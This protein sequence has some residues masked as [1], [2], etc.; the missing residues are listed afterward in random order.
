[1]T[2]PLS[3]RRAEYVR[4]GPSTTGCV[5]IA[6][7]AVLLG[8]TLD[9]ADRPELAVVTGGLALSAYA[10]GLMW[11]VGRSQFGDLGLVRWK[12][13]PWTLLWYSLVFGIA[14]VTWSQPQTGIA[15]QIA[16]SSVLRSLWLVTVG[17]TC[18]TIGYCADPGTSIRGSVQRGVD[19]L[20]SRF[21]DEIRS[22]AAPWLLYAIGLAARLATVATTGRL[23]YVG[24]VSSA[25]SS[26]SGLAGLLGALSLCAPLA[27]SAAAL[28]VFR[29]RL[30]HARATLLVLFAVELAFGA[31]AGGKQNF[32]I[33][34]LAV[35]IPFCAARR[36]LPK[37]SLVAIVLIFL[38]IVMPF[39]QAYRA[40]ARQGSVTL[41]PGQALAAAPQILRQTV[42]EQNPLAVVPQSIDE[43]I[44]RIRDIDSPAFYRYGGW[45]PVVLGMFLIGSGVRLLDNIVD[46]RAN[47]Q[48][49]FLV[50]LLFPS[51][52]RGEYDW[53]AIVSSLPS[54]AVVWLLSVALVFRP[55]RSG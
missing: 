39:N 16:V 17:L 55:R 22:P 40:V 21:A 50:L 20:R 49:L 27:V 51:L 3:I 47:P 6:V 7:A 46:I 36:R 24:D 9:F 19:T 5:L 8:F 37:V 44:H 33:A 18:W 26:A 42:T 38:Y 13:G 35:V 30:P 34:V 23:G 2:V 53:Q 29:E 45:L 11:I 32:I 10:L 41:T 31:A 14:T 25:V 4:L 12:I 15:A 28:Q 54:A 52:V 48:T 43:F 1:M